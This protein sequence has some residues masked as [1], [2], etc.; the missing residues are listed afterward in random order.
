[1]KIIECALVYLGMLLVIGSA[2]AGTV[3]VDDDNID[4]KEKLRL[5]REV[6]GNLIH[7]FLNPI[8]ILD[9]TRDFLVS[10]LWKLCDIGS[11]QGKPSSKPR[12]FLKGL[13]F[14]FHTPFFLVF[15]NS[16]NLFES[17]VFVTTLIKPFL[18]VL[19]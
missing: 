11:E 4:K 10:L 9:H 15:K 3:Y 12:K 17:F 5:Q 16:F 1:M 13:I 6:I 2:Y 18:G 7:S 8:R 14:A 19:L